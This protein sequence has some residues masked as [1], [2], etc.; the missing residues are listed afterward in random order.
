MEYPRSKT[1]SKVLPLASWFSAS[2]SSESTGISAPTW[3]HNTKTIKRKAMFKQ[4]QR[5]SDLSWCYNYEPL[6]I[7]TTVSYDGALGVVFGWAP[8]QELDT[9][10]SM[11]AHLRLQKRGFNVFPLQ[12]KSIFFHSPVQIESTW[13]WVE[14][15]CEP[16]LQTVF[17]FH[18]WPWVQKEM[19]SAKQ[20]LYT[21]ACSHY[22]VNRTLE[23]RLFSIFWAIAS[24]SP[25]GS[26]LSRMHLFCTK[27]HK[28]IQTKRLN[29]Q[30]ALELLHNLF[31]FI[32]YLKPESFPF[33]DLKY[34]ADI[35]PG[36]AC[37][38]CSCTAFS[39]SETNE[40]F[41]RP[42]FQGEIR[43][44]R[45]VQLLLL[46]C[47]VCYYFI[48]LSNDSSKKRCSTQEEEDTK[49]LKHNHHHDV[50]SGAWYPKQK[51]PSLLQMWRKYRLQKECV[52]QSKNRILDLDRID[53]QIHRN[54]QL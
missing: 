45:C 3:L 17:G 49:D 21:L 27:M 6:C 34:G 29:F 37:I 51:L 2:A 4:H 11:S 14:V 20:E 9:I 24:L 41:W 48:D 22:A 39:A 32:V 8:H 13:L 36:R 54:Q 50:F 31:G 1:K 19:R 42:W 35:Q 40:I 25:S 5:L 12:C 26:A 43:L 15:K 33:S 53:W 46:C 23:K 47:E 16:L 38:K 10:H 30:I 18:P 7:F 44:Q 28:A 52:E